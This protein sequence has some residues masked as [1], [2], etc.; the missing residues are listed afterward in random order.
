MGRPRI[1]LTREQIEF[2]HDMSF[3]WCRIAEFFGIS[4]RTLQTIRH[5]LGMPMG[6]EVYQNLLDPEIDT[7]ISDILQV[8]P[9]AGQTRVMGALRQRGIHLQWHR[10]RTS[11]QRV[12]PIATALRRRYSIRRRTYN[13]G[14]PN[15]LWYV[16]QIFF[17]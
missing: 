6:S 9:R 3:T 2:Y 7:I 1:V 16:F 14:Q 5:D 13:V 11:I 15:S 12:N 10:V 17:L 8:S 4:D